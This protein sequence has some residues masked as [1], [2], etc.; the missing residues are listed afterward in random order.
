[1]TCILKGGSVGK[2]EPMARQVA[3]I[4]CY[5][6]AVISMQLMRLGHD[7]MTPWLTLPHCV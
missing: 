6:P 7:T 3:C 4:T 5:Q 1:M 2:V